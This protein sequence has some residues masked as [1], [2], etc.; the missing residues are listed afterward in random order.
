[1]TVRVLISCPDRGD[2]AV[3]V[4]FV[5]LGDGWVELPCPCDRLHRFPVSP[6]QAARVELARYRFDDVTADDFEVMT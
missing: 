3:P 5:S 1:M 4:E 6:E 2:V